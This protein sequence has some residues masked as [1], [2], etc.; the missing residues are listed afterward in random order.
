[1]HKNSKETADHLFLHC[2][3]A[4]S[5]WNTLFQ[6]ARVSWA[7][8]TRVS[9]L[10]EHVS[11]FAKGAKARVLLATLWVI[12][13]ERNKRIF[14]DSREEDV[15]SRSD[16]TQFLASLSASVSKEFQDTS[17]FFIHLNREIAFVFWGKGFCLYFRC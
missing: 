14:G 5:L 6:A 10:F 3:V 9:M 13:L 2:K 16:R 8:Q 15:N 11:A 17:F 12:W 4:S 7:F 1:M